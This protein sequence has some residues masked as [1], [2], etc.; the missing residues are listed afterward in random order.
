MGS[1]DYSYSRG[2]IPPEY[3]CCDSFTFTQISPLQSLILNILIFNPKKKFL[4]ELY[5]FRIIMMSIHSVP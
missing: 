4:T 1:F 2:S 3:V 5:L